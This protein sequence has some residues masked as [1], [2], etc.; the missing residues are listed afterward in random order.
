MLRRL[1]S[2]VPVFGTF[3]FSG[4]KKDPKQKLFRTGKIFS[5]GGNRKEDPQFKP[6]VLRFDGHGSVI[7]FH[8]ASN[9]LHAV[10]V[11][12]GILCGRGQTADKVDFAFIAVFNTDTEETL[13]SGDMQ[14]VLRLCYYAAYDVQDG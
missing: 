3:L 14:D 12:A 5:L 1:F 2:F 9:A 8:Y 4:Y 6:A 7:F 13:L 10:A 11:I